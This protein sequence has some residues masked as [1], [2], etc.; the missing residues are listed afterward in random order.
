MV[1]H[2]WSEMSKLRG[3]IGSMGVEWEREYHEAIQQMGW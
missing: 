1:I 2:F 3:I